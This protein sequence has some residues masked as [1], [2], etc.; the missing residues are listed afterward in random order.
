MNKLPRKLHFVGIGGAGMAPLA[1]LCAVS[2][3][4]VSGSDNGKI[5]AE[6]GQNGVRVY[7]G[8]AAENFDCGTEMLVYSSAV[9]AD[10]PERLEAAR[11][12]VPQLCRGAALAAFVLD[13]RRSVAVSGAHGKSSITALTAHILN[14][15]GFSPGFMI[16]AQFNGRKNYSPG[17]GDIFV[18]EADESD[19]THTLL[20]PY[21]AVIPN[22][23]P[24]HAWSVGGR[25]QLE[26][27]FTLFALKSQH[28]I[29]YRTPETERFCA[30]HPSVQM[31]DLPG[32]DFSYAGFYGYEA[33][34][35]FIAVRCCMFLGCSKEDAEK[36]A[37][38]FPGIARRMTCRCCRDEFTVMED[39]AHHPTE[40]RN[41]LALLRRKYPQHH[42]RVLFQ[43]HRYARLEMFFED[44]V[45]ELANCDSLFIAPVFAAWSE[46]G[47]VNSEMLASRCNAVCV[48][49]DWQKTAEQISLPPADGRRLLLAVLGAGDVNAVFEYL[50]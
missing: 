34:N 41:S 32:E 43:P 49:N 5:N 30:G 44:F 24:D 18:T 9:P 33:L 11:H 37:E 50:G 40:V 42:L 10:N 2:G 13:Y 23:D 21:C 8:H 47:S 22:Y 39:Y 17:N 7:S 20:A 3:R 28:V 36:A 31:L 26:K 45:V 14:V 27:N 35:A 19:G 29:C 15:C 25:E 6:L 12:G 1:L 38:S 48:S 16:G 4:E 46:H